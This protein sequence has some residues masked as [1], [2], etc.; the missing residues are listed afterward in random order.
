MKRSDMEKDI[1]DSGEP[2][3]VLDGEPSPRQKFNEKFS[4]ER[5]VSPRS[6]G[7]LFFRLLVLCVALFLGVFLVYQV[8]FTNPFSSSS[9]DML[10][11]YADSF[12]GSTVLAGEVEGEN[13]SST[14]D[15]SGNSLLEADMA[16]WQVNTEAEWNDWTS[17]HNQTRIENERLGLDGE[18]T[19]EVAR[20]DNVLFDSEDGVWETYHEEIVDVSDIDDITLLFEWRLDDYRTDPRVRIQVDGDTVWERELIEDEEDDVILDGETLNVSGNDTMDVSWDVYTEDGP[21]IN[22]DE[23]TALEASYEYEQLYEA[24]VWTSDSWDDGLAEDSFITSFGTDVVELPNGSQAEVR[25]GV[26]TTGDGEIDQW[27]DWKGLE[28]GSNAFDTEDFDLSE[29]SRYSVEYELRQ[30]ENGG[31][32]IEGYV[33]EVEEDIEIPYFDVTII[34]TDS[35]VMEGEN[36]TVTVDI[37]NI[38]ELEGTQDIEL[39]DFDSNL[40]DTHENLTLGVDENETM[41]LV[42]ETEVG[43]GGTDMVT[44]QSEDD[45]DAE[46]VII[47]EKGLNLSTNEADNITSESAV[48]RGELVNMV[49]YEEAQVYFQYREEMGEEVPWENTSE[50]TMTELGDFYHEVSGLYENTDYEF[51]TTAETEE[52]T[53]YGDVLTFRTL[54]HLH[55][56]TG[57]PKYVSITDATVS[58]DLRSLRGYDEGH[59]FFR[60]RKKGETGWSE[61]DEQILTEP[62]TYSET[63]QELKPYKT[64]EYR[65]VVHGSDEDVGEIQ[66]FTAGGLG[67]AEDPFLVEDWYHLNQTRENLTAYY[68]LQNDLNE[69]SPGYDEV[70]GETA[71]EDA[72]GGQGFVPIGSNHDQQEWIDWGDEERFSGTFDG[73]GH[74]ISGIHA[75]WSGYWNGLFAHLDGGE[76]VNLSVEGSYFYLYDGDVDAYYIGAIAGRVTGGARILRSASLGNDVITEHRFTGGITGDLFE[77]EVVDCYS[78]SSVQADDEYAGGVA[79]RNDGTVENSYATGA[80]VGDGDY[81]GGLLGNND[82]DGVVSNSYANEDTV[83]TADFI[84]TDEGTKDENSGLRNTEEMTWEYEAR[85]GE[86]TYYTWNMSQDGTATWLSGEHATVE[87]HQSNVGYPALGWQEWKDVAIIVDTKPVDDIGTTSATLHGNLTDLRED[88]TEADVYFEY[89]QEGVA[90]WNETTNTTLYEAGPFNETVDGLEAYTTHEFR[91]VGVANGEEGRGNTLTFTPGGSGTGEDPFLIENWYH[92]DSVRNNLTAQYEVINDINQTSEGYGELVDTE[93][94][95]DPIGGEDSPFTGVLYGRGHTITGLEINRPDTDYVGLFAAT[96]GGRIEAVGLEDIN[97]TGRVIV[98]GL[99]GEIQAGANVHNSY[100]IGEVYA[101]QDAGDFSIAA[102]LVGQNLD[103]QITNSYSVVNVTGDGLNVA[104]LVGENYADIRRSYAAGNIVGHGDQVAGL[105]GVHDGNIVDSYSTA[106][107]QGGTLVGGLIVGSSEEAEAFVKNSYAT[108]YVDAEGTSGGLVAWD[109]ETIVENSYWNTNTTGQDTSYG[110]EPRTTEQMT[111]EYSEDPAVYE[112]WDMSSEEHETWYSG[113]HEIVR[114][115]ENNTGYPA[116]GW[117]GPHFGD[118]FVTPGIVRTVNVSDLYV[119]SIELAGAGGAGGWS[120]RGGDGAYFEGEFDVTDFDELSVYVGEG[121]EYGGSGGWGYHRGGDAAG[122]YTGAGGGS[123]EVVADEGTEKEVWLAGADA[124]GGGADTDDGY[125]TGGSGGGRCGEGGNGTEYG[126]PEDAECSNGG[127]G[128]YGGDGHG[129]GDGHP[130]G[131][132]DMNYND[133]YLVKLISA[134]AGVGASGGDAQERG[135]DGYVTV[136]DTEPIEVSTIGADNTS[137]SSALLQGE[138]TRL[139]AYDSVEAYFKHRVVGEEEWTSTDPQTLTETGEFLRQ[140]TG[141]N[142]TSRHEFKA[143]VETEDEVYEG[144]VSE[145]FAADWS[146]VGPHQLPEGSWFA[147][148]ED[149]EGVQ[150]VKVDSH[151]RLQLMFGFQEVLDNIHLYDSEDPWEIERIQNGGSTGWVSYDQFEE[152]GSIESWSEQEDVEEATVTQTFDGFMPEDVD[153]DL[154]FSAAYKVEYERD[155]PLQSDIIFEIRDGGT[156][157]TLLSHSGST[158]WVEESATYTPTGE[159]DAVR[160]NIYLQ[161]DSHPHG[162]EAWAYVD[163][164]NLTA[165]FAHSEGYRISTSYDTGIEDVSESEVTWE[166]YEPAGTDVN[167]SLAFTDTDQ[168]PEMDS[169]DWFE[170]TDGEPFVE[171]GANLT[172]EYLWFKYDLS[173]ETEESPTVESITAWINEVSLDVQTDEAT[174]IS[175]DSATLHGELIELG[176]YDDADVYFDWREEGATEWNST[177]VETL[178]DIGEFQHNLSNLQGVTTYEFRAVAEADGTVSEGDVLNFTTDYIWI[179]IAPSNALEAGVDFGEMSPGSQDV[180]AGDNNPGGNTGYNITIDPAT[181]VD[182]DLY[183][184]TD[185]GGLTSGDDFMSAEHVVHQANVTDPDGSNLVVDGAIEFNVTD[186]SLIGD[187]VCSDLVA[188]DDCWLR[189]WLNV[190][191]AQPTGDYNTTYHYCATESGSGSDVCG[192]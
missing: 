90:E 103:G 76:V 172:E 98:A 73:G 188:G 65:A 80:V 168:M 183:H 154:D 144:L 153:G 27:S 104:G 51:R 115:H 164:M 162:D 113:D 118:D 53:V 143:V 60:Y 122:T 29:G 134:G 102:G 78:T 54:R 43:E 55:V 185:G 146:V 44:V 191:E 86:E 2:G 62:D 111:W 125:E 85:N 114:D 61:T 101:G 41:D 116:L 99:V 136:S 59:A 12:L 100:S 13:T 49:G 174:D 67:T 184:F 91:A 9:G 82:G 28:E 71:N 140:V 31:P 4:K 40:V 35:P 57:P 69:T 56:E 156:W 75:E 137:A 106:S 148:V 52:E 159:V 77:G 175:H 74:S 161:S 147:D 21:G 141:L 108:G 24:G 63:I 17:E 1:G 109:G 107:V 25:L 135:D 181:N 45:E 42:W 33:L 126:D 89:R 68:E 178:T 66:S 124:G 81:F 150:E 47:E 128:G 5:D 110:G 97:I 133:E 145:F 3:F 95:W 112:E 190:P 70:A 157:E 23:V 72:P 131:V 50:K 36:L 83:D 105:A 169:E 87:D 151:N 18:V 117:Q 88:F 123:T 127:Y 46:E 14:E 177:E 186:Y 16:T 15:G 38:G 187:G 149:F 10:H 96:E 8:G 158:G 64:Y 189:Y 7:N 6:S 166:S 58:G 84:G 119:V 173:T 121:G 155:E 32:L 179:E 152:G 30:D 129:D 160:T 132:G 192:A 130:A 22:V 26:D 20:S 180:D 163:A 142:E 19:T 48:L 79:G 94:G 170:A 120:G 138:L 93:E 92:L 37:Y 176:G 139:F 167:I 182:V 171:E 39:L 11:G 165:D 34:G